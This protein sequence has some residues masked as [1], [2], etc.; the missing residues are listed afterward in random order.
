M[1]GLVPG[2]SLVEQALVPDLAAVTPLVEQAL[3]PDLAA[4][5]PLVDPVLRAG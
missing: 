5:T 3:V 2:A 4:V 1:A